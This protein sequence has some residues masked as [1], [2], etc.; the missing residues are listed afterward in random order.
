ME[1]LA[2]HYLQIGYA[3][4]ALAATMLVGAIKIAF[5]LFVDFKT[6]KQALEEQAKR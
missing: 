4:F 1:F 3:L 2:N 6:T 5:D